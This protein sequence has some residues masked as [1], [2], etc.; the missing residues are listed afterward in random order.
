M[1]ALIMGRLIER[2]ARSLGMK[3]SLS[4]IMDRLGAIRLSVVIRQL[5]VGKQAKQSNR[6]NV[7]DLSPQWMLEQAS[8]QIMNLYEAI[9]PQ[10]A[11]F[12]YT[13]SSDTSF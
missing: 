4:H 1:L 11:P 13:K 10:R 6:K 9:V 3:E 5:G 7:A 8:P 12:V 2:E